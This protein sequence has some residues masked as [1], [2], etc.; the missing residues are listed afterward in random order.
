MALDVLLVVTAGSLGVHLHRV[1]TEGAPAASAAGPGSPAAAAPVSVARLTAPSSPLATFGVVAERNLF[2]PTRNEVTPDPPKPALT[3]PVVATAPPARPQLHGVVMGRDGGARAYLEDPRTR[4]VFG[5]VV[6]DTVAESRLEQINADRVV[7]RRGTETFEVPLRDP[8]KP[9]PVAAAPS[10]PGP[11]GPGAVPAQ[12]APGMAAG[13]APGVTPGGSPG[14]IHQAPAPGQPYDPVMQP[15]GVP[16]IPG[17][18][19]VPGQPPVVSGR[20]IPTARPA[21]PGPSP[22]LPAPAP[23]QPGA[24]YPGQPPGG[25][26][27]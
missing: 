26:G 1:W 12:R 14:E 21:I 17:A 11:P 5:Y 2:S 10:P 4:R 15:G 8:S 20:R 22:R 23:G 25:A 13:L 3:P 16:V 6:G 9:K 7:L 24:P 27:S 19:V 18:P